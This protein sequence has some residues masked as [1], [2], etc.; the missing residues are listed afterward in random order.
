MEENTSNNVSV[1]IGLEDLR[2]TTEI[3]TY[4]ETQIENQEKIILLQQKN[5]T[6]CS[7]ILYIFCLFFIYIFTRN[8]TKRGG[9]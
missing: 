6:I 3:N 5:F 4:F 1:D 7:A 2:E 8:M 9:H